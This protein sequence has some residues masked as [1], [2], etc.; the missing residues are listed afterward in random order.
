MFELDKVLSQWLFNLQGS[1]GIGWL[2]RILGSYTLWF[3]I[4]I[5]LL[6]LFKEGLRRR[7]YLFGLLSLLLI[8]SRGIIVEIIR[9][10]YNRPRP[11]LFLDIIPLQSGIDS[12]SFPSGHAVTM[13][14]IA[15]VIMLFGNRRWT[16][17]V[18]ILASISALSR[19]MMG[20]HWFSDIVGGILLAGIVFAIFYFWVLPLK[21]SRRA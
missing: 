5:F 15:F 2:V 16:W 3:L 20:I 13:F 8:V 11:F 4:I 7:V 17:T 12:W 14:S 1:L 6:L 9:Y 21:F 18:F 19:V 10:F